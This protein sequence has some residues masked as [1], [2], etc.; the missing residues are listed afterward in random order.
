MNQVVAR[1]ADGTANRTARPLGTDL[2][3]TVA[4]LR[5]SREV[6]NN[7]RPQGRLKELPSRD[8][9]IVIVDQLRAALFP[10]HFGQ[11][12]LAEE[13]IDQFVET[14]LGWA[15]VSLKEQV[16]RDLALAAEL[17]RADRFEPD[18]TALI[19][20][21]TAELPGIRSTLFADISA[22]YDGDPAANSAS[23]I[24]L[25]Y[26]GITAIIHHRLANVLWQLGA[27]LV[28][29]LVS[30]IAHSRTAID[31]HPG[32]TI[33][34]G[35]FIDHGTGVVI[36]ETTIIG[37]NVRLYQSVTLGAKRFA[38][39]EDG[40]LAKGGARHPIIE[41]DVVIYAGATVLGR[42]TIGKGSSIGG[43]IWL[44]HSVPAGSNITQAKAQ[45][46]R[47]ADGGGI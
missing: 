41:D 47:F 44:T 16:R 28:A 12:D 31:I 18:A 15:L 5:I 43:N 13:T 17:P 19:A 14:T 1:P 8:D 30:D 4:A 46:E 6:T 26:P 34:K 11:V 3:A 32:A 45:S 7:I 9:L 23:E 35:F 25:C 27:P 38:T 33:G 36:G 22:A 40:T 2:A 42:I 39:N 10:S 21:F 37:T 24:L 29:R 20:R